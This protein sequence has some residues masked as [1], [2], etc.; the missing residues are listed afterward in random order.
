MTIEFT[1]G[2]RAI[3]Q[4][5]HGDSDAIAGTGFWVGDRYLITCAHV[6]EPNPTTSSD[7][8]VGRQINV[9]FHQAGHPQK[10]SASV[11]D[12]QYEDREGGQDVAV[13]QL[14]QEAGL[15]IAPLQLASRMQSDL[16]ATVKT[17]GYIKGNTVGRTVTACTNGFA[18]NWVQLEVVQT[19]GTS[20]QSGL[21]GAPVWCQKSKT[22]VGIVVARD[23]L[24]PG[25]R[26]GFMIPTAYLQTASSLVQRCLMDRMDDTASRLSRSAADTLSSQPSSFA[27]RKLRALEKRKAVLIR[28]YEAASD[29]LS[30]LRSE[31]DKITVGEEVKLIERELS[32]VEDDITE[33][34]PTR[35]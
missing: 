1:E 31:A 23:E 11:I 14:S 34:L 33:L 26:V 4:V 35:G 16:E 2:Q 17:Y 32:Q 12:Y 24:N 30:A 22:F 18:G 25:D 5:F 19:Q 8:I 10:L 6:I 27:Q 15:N 7:A 21:S 3:V 9:A 29:Q 13:L 28:K 20:I